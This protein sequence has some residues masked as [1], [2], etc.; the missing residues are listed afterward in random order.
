M[1]VHRDGGTVFDEN[2]FEKHASHL[3]GLDIGIRHEV[4]FGSVW[5]CPTNTQPFFFRCTR[6]NKDVSL[7]WNLLLDTTA[8]GLGGDQ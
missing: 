2:L 8:E 1:N 7:P 3:A 6:V 4:S 5:A